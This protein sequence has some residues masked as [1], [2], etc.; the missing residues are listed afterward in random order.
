MYIGLSCGSLYL[1]QSQSDYSV[2]CD[3]L[4]KLGV[5]MSVQLEL[6]CSIGCVNIHLSP[7]LVH[8]LLEIASGLSSP[9]RLV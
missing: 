1:I 2:F 5:N 6:D 3:K 8:L 7:H 9:G 4:L